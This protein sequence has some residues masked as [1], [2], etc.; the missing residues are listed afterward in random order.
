[1]D[2]VL[3]SNNNPDH[4][5]TKDRINQW[6]VPEAGNVLFDAS[7]GYSL[8]NGSAAINWAPITSGVTDDIDGDFRRT[9]SPPDFGADEY[10]SDNP[11]PGTCHFGGA[12]PTETPTPTATETPSSPTP[13]AT[14][15]PEC[16]IDIDQSVAQ[17]ALFYPLVGQTFTID[18]SVRPES[19]F[20]CADIN[21][22][23]QASLYG[24]IIDPSS[25]PNPL[26]ESTAV[27]VQENCYDDSGTWR[28]HELTF[29]TPVDSTSLP[30][31]TFTINLS[32]TSAVRSA[33]NLYA[34]GEA[35]YSGNFQS[36]A[37]LSFRI[38]VCP[39]LPQSPTPTATR[40]PTPLPTFTPTQFPTPTATRTPTSLPTITPTRFPTVTP[41]R[42]PTPT[43]TVFWPSPT[44]TRTPTLFPT[45]TPTALPTPTWTPAP[46]NTPLPTS[47]PTATP[48]PDPCHYRYLGDA[49]CDSLIDQADFDCWRDEYLNDQACAISNPAAYQINGRYANFS[50]QEDDQVTL[51]DF[52]IW[53]KHRQ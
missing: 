5:D 20:I 19:I 32:L 11:A 4:N 33:N 27:T 29:P 22:T 21:G 39:Y 45:N 18:S 23:Y 6:C 13:T 1:M 28:W 9:Y 17:N 46:T 40:T 3:F 14:P 2:G 16:F 48:T 15:N 50:Y 31:F 49:N 38:K 10:A 25:P 52:E 8:V 53:R 26:A 47:T 37:D 43:P 44:P 42:I 12:E 35:W 7:D 30:T 41:T 34:G 24:G 36:S 51:I